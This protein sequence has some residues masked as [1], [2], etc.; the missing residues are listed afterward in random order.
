MV[1]SHRRSLAILI[2]AASLLAAG[3][4]PAQAQTQLAAG[5]PTV[6]KVTVSKVELGTAANVYTT[7]FTG[8]AQLD[9]VAAAGASAFPGISNVTLPAGTYTTVRVTFLNSFGIQ[10]SLASS[11]TTYYTTATSISANAAAAATTVSSQLAEATLLNPAWGA[12]GTAVVQT[13]TLPS[14]V[15]VATGQNFGP[16]IKFDVTTSLV[17]STQSG[18]FFFH[19]APITVTIIMPTVEV[20]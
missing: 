6:F 11:G 12:L 10:G 8:S 15:T 1:M 5:K 3:P 9:L 20:P 14:A 17:L 18:A 2:V 13:I 7:V 4:V 16:T 19:L